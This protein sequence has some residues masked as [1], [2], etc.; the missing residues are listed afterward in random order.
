MAK[1]ITIVFHNLS[2]Y[3]SHFIIKAFAKNID[4]DVDVIPRN[5]E[6]YISFTKRVNTTKDE[7]FSGIKLRFI[8]S[9]RFMHS[10]LDYLA[11]LLPSDKKKILRQEFSSLDENKLKLLEKK[12]VFC[13]DYLDSVEKLN[14][15]SLP[16][17]EMFYSSLN[18]SHIADEDYEHA[19][20]VWKTFDIKTLGEYS[21]LYMKI[22]ADIFENFRDTCLSTYRLDPAH[23][24]TAP[25]LSY[26]AMLKYTK[27]ELELITDIDMLL[28]V[29]RGIRGG[30]SQCSKRHAKANNR[31]MSNYDPEL[32]SNFLIYL[33]ANNLY[34]WSMLQHLPVG[35]YKWC[36]QEFTAAD[37]MSLRDD[38]CVGYIFEVD[39]EYP[40]SLHDLHSDY[41]FCAENKSVPYTKNEKKLLL[42]LD[43]KKEY[44]LHY[45]MLKIALQNGLILKKV[46]R[47]LQFK[48][49]QWLKP[50]IEINTQ[51]RTQATNEFEKALWKLFINAVFGKTLE[52]V[53]DRIDIKL[54]CKWDG[55]YGA[56]SYIAMPNFK[57]YKIF[58]EDL[59][60]IEMRQTQA[61]MMKPIAIGMSILDISKVLMYDFYYGYMK[62]KY[63]DKVFLCYTDTDSFLMDISTDC[64]YSDMLADIQIYD[65]SDFE[66]SNVYG[67]PRMNKKVPGLFKDELKGSIA[68]EF[69]GLRSKMYAVRMQEKSEKQ[70][71]KAKGVK[72][73]VLEKKINFKDYLNCIE[74]KEEVVREQNTIRSK[75]HQVYTI[76]QTKV[77]LS[78]YDNKRYILDGNINTLPWGHYKIPHNLD[79]NIFHRKKASVDQDPNENSN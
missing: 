58:D 65:T 31:Y 22:L 12:G 44:V 17:K 25:G 37:I 1:Y 42:T 77:A 23:F 6:V 36:H 75:K 40:E 72:K 54:K 30:I 20:L 14:E 52:N 79:P 13:Y 74:S 39:L 19:K 26:E 76:T 70:I 49:S 38:S 32:E 21:D 62:K 27:V 2:N 29:E 4:G 11:S 41:P 68:T 66:E 63:G 10:S 8:D 64:F 71:R 18:D 34:G 7:Y 61:K 24:F 73:C 16:P 53:R 43:D 15:T 59:V 3:D 46:H 47:V 28:F 9:L 50:Y 69:V 51:L 5:D 35:D 33:D 48:Q 55:R 67:I 45:R 57:K 56:R 78:A 60:A